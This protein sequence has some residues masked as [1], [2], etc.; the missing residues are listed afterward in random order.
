MSDL[1]RLYDRLL[2]HAMWMEPFDAM[3]TAS[4]MAG[5]MVR[6]DTLAGEYGLGDLANGLSF[7]DDG[8]YEDLFYGAYAA[9]RAFTEHDDPHGEPHAHAAEVLHTERVRAQLPQIIR[10]AVQ[11]VFNGFKRRHDRDP[12]FCLP[13]TDCDLYF[14]EHQKTIKLIEPFLPPSVECFLVADERIPRTSPMY[15]RVRYEDRFTRLT[16]DEYDAL[17]RRLHDNSPWWLRPRTNGSG[18]SP[19]LHRTHWDD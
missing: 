10:D 9:A 8:E 4:P 13:F 3:P 6:M 11:V 5:F 16:T 12:I 2:G 15:L 17:R 19:G 18:M 1:E 14:R 7:W